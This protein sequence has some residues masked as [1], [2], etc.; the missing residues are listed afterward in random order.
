MTQHL[1]AQWRYLVL[2][3]EDCNTCLHKNAVYV[4]ADQS[5]GGF[6]F[7]GDAYAYAYPHPCVPDGER[8]AL[9]RAIVDAQWELLTSPDEAELLQRARSELK[10][11]HLACHCAGQR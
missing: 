7:V 11:R 9:H 6:P 4:G 8:P 2:D 10:G 3:A 5:R 1:E